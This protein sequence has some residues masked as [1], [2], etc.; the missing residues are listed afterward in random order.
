MLVLSSLRTT[1]RARRISG[2]AAGGGMLM[3]LLA[4]FG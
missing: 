1:V 3:G 4:S 2:M